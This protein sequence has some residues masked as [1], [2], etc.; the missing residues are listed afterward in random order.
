VN[1]Y[2][3]SYLYIAVLVKHLLDALAE[4][5]IG[6]DAVRTWNVHPSRRNDHH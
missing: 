4:R 6:I 3:G 5:R 1:R 2:R